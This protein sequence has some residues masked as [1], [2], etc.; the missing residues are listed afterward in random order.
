M[1]GMIMIRYKGPKNTGGYRRI[2]TNQTK[3]ERIVNNKNW[4]CC[5]ASKIG[6]HLHFS[7]SKFKSILLAIKNA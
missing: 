6:L 7:S 1:T 2:H 5:F 4:L 3:G